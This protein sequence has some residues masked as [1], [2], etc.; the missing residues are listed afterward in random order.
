MHNPLAPAALRGVA[1][2]QWAYWCSIVI[3]AL[4]A[5][6]IFRR[7]ASAPQSSY[8]QCLRPRYACVAYWLYQASDEY[9]RTRL[10]LSVAFT[11]MVVARCA[12]GYFVLELIGFPRGSMIWIN[13][14]GWSVFN[15]QLLYVMFRS[16]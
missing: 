8:L 9:I 3:A 7:E 10:L 12:L 6:S 15:L 1:Y 2:S 11:A 4:S 13:L 14:L 16:R 5:P